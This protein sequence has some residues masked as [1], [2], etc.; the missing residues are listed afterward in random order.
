M[1]KTIPDLSRPRSGQRPHPRRKQRHSS[2]RIRQ[3]AVATLVFFIV[4]VVA[5]GLSFR[6]EV[7]PG[8][9]VAGI[10]IGGLS[11]ADAKVRLK[12]EFDARL[13]RSIDVTLDRQTAAMIPG[14][15]DAEVDIKATVD[16]AMRTGRL[17]SLL[18]PFVYSADAEPLLAIPRRPRIPATLRLVAQPPR[19]AAVKIV[20]GQAK[21]TPARDGRSVSAQAVLRAAS[22]A[23]IDGRE[24][25]AL[26]SKAVS[27]AVSTAEAR[28]AATAALA[29]AAAPVSLFVDG[30][31]V[32]AL[33]TGTLA[34]AVI[35]REE[36]GKAQIAFDPKRLAPALGEALGTEIRDAQN[37]IWDTNGL[38]AWV[39]PATSG[40]GFEPRAAANAVRDAAVAGGARQATI[41]MTTIDP[42]RATK[43][44]EQFKITERVAG[45]T[46]N[47]GDSSENRI[48]N[49][50][51]MAEILDLRLVLAGETFSFN[52]AVGPRTPERGFREGLAISGGL[53]IPSIGGGVCQVATTLYDAAFAMGLSL[54]QRVNHSFYIS[55]YGLGMDAA[56]SWGGPDLSFTNN[57]DHPLLI[58]ATAD[59]STMI[60]NLYSAPADG[61]SIETITG[62]RYN[63]VPATN[64]YL[65]DPLAP[66]GKVVPYTDGQDGFSVDVTRIVK[67]NGEILSDD[68]FAST[69]VPEGKTFL[70]GPGAYPPGDYLAEAPPYGWKSPFAT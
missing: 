4:V 36:G 38:R 61:R 8:V 14:E 62:E 11:E 68:I 9:A 40:R 48:Y 24:S 23:A 32:G 46:T 12:T 57:T 50:A 60:V 34:T 10:D 28:Q 69:Y 44:A 42:G 19:S 21:V 33:S 58:R 49:V 70:V 7:A 59:A 35:V 5:R 54:G 47:L 22:I 29:M 53:L 3:I 30:K 52:N 13:A 17:R 51:L 66:A 65:S 15:L 20:H 55:H 37:A 6:G 1:A 2:T 43:E 41:K 45:A 26:T 56:V 67:L 31:R 16:T 63:V 18:L 39:V 27:P 64:R 25:V